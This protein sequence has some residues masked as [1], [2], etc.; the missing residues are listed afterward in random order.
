M[1]NLGGTDQMFNLSMSCS[2]CTEDSQMED[3]RMEDSR[4]EDSRMEDSR[5]NLVF[6][7]QQYSKS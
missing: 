1:S 2:S 4:M 7:N 5:Y 3:S 6:Q